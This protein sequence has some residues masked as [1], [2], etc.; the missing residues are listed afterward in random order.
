MNHNETLFFGFVTNGHNIQG[1]LIYLFL[2]FV[3]DEAYF[4]FLSVSGEY[5]Y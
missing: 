2:Y 1:M 3:L 5:S 4:D